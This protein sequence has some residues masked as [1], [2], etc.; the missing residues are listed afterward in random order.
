ML[1]HICNFRAWSCCRQQHISYCLQRSIMIH[2][3]SLLQSQYVNLAL[4]LYL[5]DASSQDNQFHFQ[6]LIISRNICSCW[7]RIETS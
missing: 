4:N 5:H 2:D 1:S 3:P 6:Y 7:G